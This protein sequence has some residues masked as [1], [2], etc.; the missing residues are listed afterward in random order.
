MLQNLVEILKAEN[1]MIDT[2]RLS[3]PYIKN[4]TKFKWTAIQS[5][6]KFAREVD[7]KKHI[8]SKLEGQIKNLPEKITFMSCVNIPISQILLSTNNCKTLNL[9]S[10]FLQPFQLE[11]FIQIR[12]KMVYSSLENIKIE[13]SNTNRLEVK[14]THNQVEE[15]EGF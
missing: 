14:L 15:L 12:D 7:I 5:L 6:Q 13:D 2:L 9:F 8:F 4:E 10:C 11:N 3:F 1:Q